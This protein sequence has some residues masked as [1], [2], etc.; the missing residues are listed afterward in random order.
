MQSRAADGVTARAEQEGL[1]SAY[2]KQP[3]L[4]KGSTVAR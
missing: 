3:G 4:T 2:A 1:G